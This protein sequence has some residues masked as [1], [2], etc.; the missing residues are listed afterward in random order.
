MAFMVTI[1]A[2]TYASTP[3]YRKRYMYLDLL[4]ANTKYPRKYIWKM[5]V[6]LKIKVFMWFFH[7]KVISNK[8]NLIK[9]IGHRLT[10]VVYVIACNP[11]KHLF[12]SAHLL[13]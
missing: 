4:N 1:G 12:F 10:H 7:R 6:P 9:R 5:E 2:A 13:K 3:H 11:Y 8:D